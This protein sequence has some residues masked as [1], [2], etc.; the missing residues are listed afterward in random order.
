MGTA[1]FAFNFNNNSSSDTLL[2]LRILTLVRTAHTRPLR[3]RTPTCEFKPAELL[4]SDIGAACAYLF[5]PDGSDTVETECCS[6]C[7]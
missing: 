7:W 3:H 2:I 5:A 1:P 6:L 4:Y